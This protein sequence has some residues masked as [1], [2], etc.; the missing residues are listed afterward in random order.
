MKD[1]LNEQTA[2]CTVLLRRSQL[3]ITPGWREGGF[4]Q[5]ATASAPPCPLVASLQS[6]HLARDPA[7]P[8]VFTCVSV[9]FPQHT[10]Y[11]PSLPLDGFRSQYG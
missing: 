5:N 3:S 8:S 9:N 4:S 7:L 2:P 11:L 1:S 6:S 10:L